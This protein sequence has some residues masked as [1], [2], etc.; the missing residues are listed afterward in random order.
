MTQDTQPHKTVVCPSC[1][2]AIRIASAYPAKP[3]KYCLYCGTKLGTTPTSASDTLSFVGDE[4]Q[5]TLVGD[6]VPEKEQILF[7]LG[8]YQILDKIGKGGMGEV[9]LAYDTTCGRKI[10]LKRI[11]A[12]LKDV[13][14]LYQRFLN[15][16]RITSQLTHPSI[17]PI[18]SIHTDQ[19]SLYYTMPYIEG[20]NFKELIRV[21]R[22]KEAK[23]EPY[24]EGGILPLVRI[25]INL[26]HAI[27]YAHSKGVLH[28]DIKP[29]NIIVGKF[30]E[31]LILDWGLAK[32]LND[33][34]GS[35]PEIPSKQE[36]ITS[37]GKV[38]GTVS[39][40]APERVKGQKAS[41]QTDIYALGV[42]LYQILTLHLP[43]KRGDL[44]KFRQNVDLERLQ[45]PVE[46]A[47][48]RD[49][50]EQL[51]KIVH[52]CLAE[53]STR[54]TTVDLL[55]KDIQNFIEGSSEWFYSDTLTID[56]PTDWEFQANVL[57]TEHSAITRHV[58]ESQWVN[59]MISQRSF[60]ASTKIEGSVRIQ[61]GGQ[62]FGILLSVPEPSLREHL[63]EG[64]CLWI[65][66]KKGKPTALLKTT[67]EVYQSDTFLR[68]N[69]WYSFRIEKIDHSLYFYLDDQLQ[70]SYISHTPVQGSHV[71]ILLR[72]SQL[73]LEP[74]KVYEAGQNVLVS[75]LSVP[76]ALFAH[77]EYTKA[78]SEYRRIGYSFPGRTEGREAIM[79]AGMTLI[80][81]A[82]E[83]QGK[84]KENYLEQSFHEFE[85]LNKTPYAPLEYLG[86][87]FVYEAEKNFEDEVKC[88]EL[89]I[90][91]YPKHPMLPMIYEE[92]IYRMH[93]CSASHRLATYLFVVLVLRHMKKTA[94][95]PHALKLF[96]KI[97]THG[98]TPSFIA[99]GERFDPTTFVIT[100]AY[101]VKKSYVLEEVFLELLKH[102]PLDERN[103][104]NVC[105]S[106]IDLQAG[107]K[108]W[109]LFNLIESHLS[110]SYKQAIKLALETLSEPFEEVIQKFL[111]AY[112]NE[113]IFQR[114]QFFFIM[115]AIEKH[116]PKWLDQLYAK[117]T[118]HNQEAHQQLWPLKAW[119]DFLQ[120]KYADLKKT[121]A[122]LPLLEVPD[123][124]SYTNFLFGVYLAHE[125]GKE[126]AI[127]HFRQVLD[128]PYPPS[129]AL[130]S[131]YLCGKM[132][133]E[134]W[135][136]NAFF[137]E[138]RE[139]YYQLALY[140]HVLGEE[141]KRDLF[142]EKAN[143]I[144]ML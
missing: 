129:W 119:S 28:R 109:P 69:I 64:Y 75:C 73:T 54:Y 13:E 102:P 71:G 33:A 97:S 10:A 5:V 49:V 17:M 7:E 65:S 60:P 52:Q 77:K 130:G 115:K 83:S 120:K 3:T 11:R 72:D 118:Y 25:F 141:T 136:K 23:G 108:A 56:K 127:D 81:Q 9:F 43:F 113:E 61:R 122:N 87:A 76:D 116:Q 86:K 2:G 95:T 132:D 36:G 79:R 38:V 42:V 103:I 144:L 37:I 104:S 92:I 131:H 66:A 85:K 105:F 18:Y 125:R 88:F 19:D 55:I 50:P 59:L 78:L 112:K 48:Y 91:R 20:K 111:E 4:T 110:P 58:E 46:L 68:K 90:R 14:A 126:A 82:K 143:N 41:V 57:I 26:C 99:K 94:K 84:E 62:G 139:L 100:M 35:Y 6:A 107:D 31:V 47:P 8:P 34:E 15:E 134:R 12:D 89:A 39:Y 29:E 140:Y 24:P 44:K 51:V 124:N 53:P 135:E 142:H 40:L 16:A 45:D 93:E 30:G 138:K 114:A 22:R 80:Q 121:L 63:N 128:T 137:W 123:E 101:M 21:A 117:A 32:L 27:S 96:E 74:L 106:L 133:F 98:E 70:F 67:Y 1:L